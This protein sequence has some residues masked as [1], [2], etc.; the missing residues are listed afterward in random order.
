LQYVR[1]SP[2]LAPTALFVLLPGKTES[3]IAALTPGEL[4][5]AAGELFITDTAHTQNTK[6]RYV[7]G[8]LVSKAFFLKQKEL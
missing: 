3:I 1:D 5:L 8:S 6:Y 4:F 7:S 2:L